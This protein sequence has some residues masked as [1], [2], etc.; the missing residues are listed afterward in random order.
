MREIEGYLSGKEKGG[1]WERIS[2]SG[3]APG[4]L[5]NISLA[6]ANWMI[7][8]FGTSEG[9]SVLW[10]YNIRNGWNGQDSKVLS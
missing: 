1:T 3:R 5:R 7:Y 8:V 4:V 2:P 6:E 9:R 10:V